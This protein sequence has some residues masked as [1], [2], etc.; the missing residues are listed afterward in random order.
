MIDN[1]E[2]KGANTY[3]SSYISE[4]QHTQTAI[5]STVK[6]TNSIPRAPVCTM[7]MFSWTAC[8]FLPQWI[9]SE[10]VWK[11]QLQQRLQ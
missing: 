6:K 4:Q 10:P 1:R 2:K 5:I 11:E 3:F 7:E 8:E 9:T